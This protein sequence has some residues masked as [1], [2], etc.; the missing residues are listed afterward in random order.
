MADLY[1][2]ET[3]GYARSEWVNKWPNSTTDW[4]W[5]WWW[6]VFTNYLLWQKI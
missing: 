2:E 1:S 6:T 3:S 5:W 4:W